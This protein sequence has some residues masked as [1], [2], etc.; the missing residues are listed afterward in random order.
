V[1]SAPQSPRFESHRV[2]GARLVVDTS[3][4]GAADARA[5]LEP[6]ELARRLADASGAR[7]RAATALLR[8][9][10]GS[11]ALLR[12][13][14]HGGLLAP[15]WGERLLG[16][17]RALRELR[18][19]AE[20]HAR[21]APV[22]RPLLVVGVRRGLF[23]HAAL[24]TAYEQD[25]RDGLALL[26]AEPPR[27]R[28]ASALDA[29]ARAVRHFHDAGG[30]HADLHLGNLLFREGERA[31]EALVIDLDG[32]RA[33][34]P[35]GAPRRMR[36]LMRLYRSA[37]KRGQLAR[38]GARGCARFLSAYC[39]GDRALRRALLASLP[40]ERLR[41]AR[42]AASWRIAGALSARGDTS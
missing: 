17:G 26:A 34:A 15:L 25:A 8:A 37:G 13:V 20:L 36:E 23:W 24:A 1:E 33:G 3:W 21:G 10:D 28:L 18:V 12:P 39:A 29:A 5:L 16:L 42:H 9:R 41:L 7:G 14:R 27:A 22:S 31:C 2:R 40:R 32:A 19:A 38:I 30:H 11:C 35:P 6:G 4:S